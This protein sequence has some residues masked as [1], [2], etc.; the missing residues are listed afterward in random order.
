MATTFVAIPSLVTVAGAL[1]SGEKDFD[2]SISAEAAFI[3]RKVG[4]LCALWKRRV[5]RL[6]Q[7]R[8][9]RC[10]PKAK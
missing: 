1:K 3:V 9:F 10:E 6:I 4:L 7:G 5:E 8:L 2:P